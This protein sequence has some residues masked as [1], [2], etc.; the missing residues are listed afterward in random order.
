VSVL[1]ERHAHPWLHER[2]FTTDALGHAIAN[3][4]PVG[5]V[6]V[7][8]DRGGEVR[9][10]AR[11]KEQPIELT[12]PRG[13]DAH[14]TVTRRDGTPVPNAKV[15]L[16]TMG[17][18]DLVR[19]VTRADAEGRY[20]VRDVE[21]DRVFS[22]LTPLQRP[23][24]IEI[25]RG[26]PGDSVEINL[27]FDW[28]A[29]PV[30]GHVLDPKGKPIQGARVL[31]GMR[32]GPGP[33]HSGQPPIPLITNH[34]GRFATESAPTPDVVLSARALGYAPWS[35]TVATGAEEIEVMLN[36][37]ASV[38]GHATD[39]HGRGIEGARIE[40]RN[41]DARPDLGMRPPEW[42]RVVAWSGADGAFR[43]ENASAERNHALAISPDGM[44]AT[45]DLELVEGAV[46]AWNPRLRKPGRIA[47]VVVDEA[48][49]PLVNWGVTLTAPPTWD[50]PGPVHTDAQGAFQFTD[51]DRGSYT[52][53]CT[54]PDTP[55]P[56]AAVQIRGVRI[57]DSPISVVVPSK[58]MAS[59]HF[60]GVLENRVGEQ[61]KI[62]LTAVGANLDQ[63]T[64]LLPSSGEF[65]F[66]PVPPGEYMLF[67][68]ADT[69]H[70]LFSYRGPLD[71]APE[72]TVDLGSVVY[73]GTGTL[74]VVADD[75]SGRQN[76]LRVCTPDGTLANLEPVSAGP[77]ECRLHAGRYY[78][79]VPHHVSPK[80]WTPV[81]VREGEHT[82]VFFSVPPSAHRRL[83][84]RYSD[85][86]RVHLYRLTWRDTNG[87]LLSRTPVTARMP[88]HNPFS[89]DFYLA[90][91]DYRI[92]LLSGTGVLATAD[93]T[94]REEDGPHTRGV[95]L[96]MR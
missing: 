61:S 13:I 26:S 16:S 55:L 58:S 44:R 63:W 12:I 50:T 41:K 29:A 81:D 38:A 91:G 71:V 7:R 35:S 34:E 74:R 66:G 54:Q 28:P 60:K 19:V 70:P 52:L 78:V 88:K 1:P 10:I 40:L 32:L 31:V 37:G 23:A 94:V 42:N 90:P 27:R 46:H 86:E 30:R 69:E 68:I 15:T 80:G 14:G 45:E 57:E 72:Q 77:L 53:G 62:G 73:G 84:I 39:A 43:I 49:A 96:D 33:N 2:W 9:A 25:L 47:G 95:L 24:W 18:P 48:G 51:C 8:G 11:R 75:R 92:E 89:L 21:G 17:Q 67:F 79:D 20:A 36:P 82:E 6:V 93:V 5:P 87:T 64:V 59:A 85:E 3:D 76:M 56:G 65:H 22:A 4:W 83:L